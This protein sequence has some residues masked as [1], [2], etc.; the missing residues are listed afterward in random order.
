M[1]AFNR[2]QD[3]HSIA[4]QAGVMFNPVADTCIARLYD[5]ARLRGG[6]IYNGYTGSSINMHVAS[7]EP[8]WICIDLIW[9]SFHYP[10]IQMKCRKVFGQ[11]RANNR[12]ALEFD[13]KL[14]F[15]EETRISDVF[16]DGD[17]IILSMRREDCRWLKLRPRNLKEPE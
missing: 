5:D 4:A 1:I 15:K 10:F 3:G 17:L 2:P 16:P 8:T 11:V 12:A 9:V 6:V 14:G 13:R 7:F